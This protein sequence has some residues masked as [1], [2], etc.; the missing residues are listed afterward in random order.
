M[1][2]FGESVHFRPVGEKNAMRGGDPKMIRGV[3]VG[4][5]ERF[6]AAV[7]LTPEGVNRG[8]RI[9]RMLE[10]DP[11]DHVFKYHGL[12]LDQRKLPKQVVPSSDAEQ[13]FAPIVLI[14]GALRVDLMRDVTER[15]LAKYGYIDECLVCRSSSL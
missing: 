7:S 11:W 5:S 3:Y 1:V 4:H 15:D 8:T 2:E 14:P 6:G 12:R 13:G 9:S 10:R